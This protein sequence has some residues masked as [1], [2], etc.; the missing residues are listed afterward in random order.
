MPEPHAADD[1]SVTT[2][3]EVHHRLF[4]RDTTRVIGYKEF[5]DLSKKLDCTKNVLA[6]TG[7]GADMVTTKPMRAIPVDVLDQV[8]TPKMIAQYKEATLE[9]IKHSWSARFN[10]IEDATNM[11]KKLQTEMP[12]IEEE[13]AKTLA[14]DP[15][16]NV[17]RLSEVLQ[18]LAL[19]QA[20]AKTDEATGDDDGVEEVAGDA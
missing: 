14:L 7:P 6:K 12:F 8:F 19:A 3:D 17:A 18:K 4:C 5:T 16:T 9:K 15:D 20:V 2:Y 13:Y 10:M 11:L 1:Y